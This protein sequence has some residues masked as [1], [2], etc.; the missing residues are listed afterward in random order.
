MTVSAHAF[1]NLTQ[2]M[3]TKAVALNN[4][5]TLAVALIASGTITWNATTQGYTTLSGLITGASL[6]EVSSSGTGYS[7]QNLTSVT[8]TTSGLVNTLTCANPA[9]ANS[10]FSAVYA[11][12]YDSTVSNDLLCYWDFGG[13]QS[14]SGATFTLQISA[15]GLI[16]W[17]SS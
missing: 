16:T 2:V 10:T 6:T 11:V 7:R 3:G 8:Y 17:T 12:F 1:P 15:S 5:D 4:S 13:S 9:W 14:V